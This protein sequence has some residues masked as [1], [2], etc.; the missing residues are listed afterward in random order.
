MQVRINPIKP[1]GEIFAIAS[2]SDAHRAIICSALANENT[3]ISISHISKD[4]EATFNCIK[5]MGAEVIKKDSVY[6]IIPIKQ[7]TENPVLNCSESG[8]TLRFLLPVLSA[9]GKGATFVGAGRLPQRPMELMIDLLR[10]HGN[11]FSAS[12]LPITVSGKTLPGIFPIAGNVSSQFI[13]GL[14]FALPLLSEKSKIVLTSPLQSAAYVDMTINTLKHFGANIALGENAFTIEPMGVYRSP[15]EYIV[16]GDW[17]NAAFFMVLGALNG[18]VT[19]KNLNLDSCQ[20]DKMI[21]DVLTLAGVD[22]RVSEDE[23]TVLKSKIKPFD[24][25]VS[26]C[27]DLFPVL[28]ILA[29]GAEGKTTLYNAERLRIKESDRIKT[30][31]DLIVN[32]GG[33]ADETEDSLIIYGSGELAGGTVNSAND[34]RIAMSAFV[35]SAIC[36]RDIIL[37]DAAAINKSY[38]SFINDF[39]QIGGKA[40]VI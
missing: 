10:E 6:E 16:E 11:A 18:S 26:Q 14:L 37:E 9:L 23:I 36:R 39:E 13:S 35:A 29:C 31:K 7:Q 12:K 28:S 17:S 19:I 27:P 1:D 5:A 4:I 25:D 8:S 32:L 2:K 20:S 38:P 21:L 40:Y 22:F 3:N 24:F 33:K 34:H 15:K 30:T